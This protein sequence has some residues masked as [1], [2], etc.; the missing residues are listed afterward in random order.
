MNDHDRRV[1]NIMT[2]GLMILSAALLFLAIATAVIAVRMAL[3]P[4]S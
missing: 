3:A 4:C 2:F 1:D